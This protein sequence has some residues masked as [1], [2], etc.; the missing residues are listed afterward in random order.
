MTRELAREGRL[1]QLAIDLADRPGQLGKVA[2]L[3]GEAGANIVEVYHQR[4]FCDLPAKGALLEVVIETRDRAHL[5]ETVARLKAAG[6]EIEVRSN[7]GGT[8]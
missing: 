2:D 5:Q 7:P 1:S 3:L 8:R 4:V 6:F